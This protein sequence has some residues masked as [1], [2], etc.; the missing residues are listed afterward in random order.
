MSEG[1]TIS[2]CK[3]L[4]IDEDAVSARTFWRD[5]VKGAWWKITV[6]RRLR[7]RNWI[8]LVALGAK[9]RAKIMVDRSP[10][11]NHQT[12]SCQHLH[13]TSCVNLSTKLSVDFRLVKRS[14]EPAI[15]PR[16]VFPQRRCTRSVI[17]CATPGCRRTITEKKK[18][19]SCLVLH[20]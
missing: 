16:E 2:C 12:Y 13:Q 1:E 14:R 18:K 19:F 20:C 4:L 8:D 6:A 15:D 5:V 11:K 3:D 9:A 7:V 10:Q 17:H